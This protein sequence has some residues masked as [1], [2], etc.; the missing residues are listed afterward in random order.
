VSD[1]VTKVNLYYDQVSSGVKLL[2]FEGK[3]EIRKILFNQ[4]AFNEINNK[5]DNIKNTFAELDSLKNTFGGFSKLYDNFY[6]FLNST[7]GSIKK[8]ESI[9]VTLNEIVRLSKLLEKTVNELYRVRGQMTIAYDYIDIPV[10]GLNTIYGNSGPLTA[11]LTNFKT[12]YDVY[13]SLKKEKIKDTNS[14]GVTVPKKNARNDK[15][16]HNPVQ[17]TGLVPR[18]NG[19]SEPQTSVSVFPVKKHEN[20]R[21][22][23]RAQD[24]VQ[25]NSQS[26]EEDIE[27][28][29]E[30]GDSPA[31]NE[32]GVV[33][34]D[35]GN[36]ER[37]RQTVTEGHVSLDSI[38][39]K[40]PVG[41]RIRRSDNK[42]DSSRGV[43]IPNKNAK[44]DKPSHRPVK[45]TGLAPRNNGNSEPHPSVSIVGVREHKR[46]SDQGE[47]DEENTEDEEE[48]EEDSSTM[49]DLTKVYRAVQP[50]MNN[51][52]SEPQ[53]VTN[54]SV[55][56]IS[57]S[58]AE[59]SQEHDNNSVTEG[60]DSSESKETAADNN[61]EMK[62]ANSART[63]SDKVTL[64][65]W[66][67]FINENKRLISGV[68]LSGILLVS[69]LLGLYKYRDTILNKVKGIKKD[70]ILNKIKETERRMSKTKERVK[71]VSKNRERVKA[72]S[73]NRKRVKA[74]SKNRE[75]VKAV[76]KN[77][78]KN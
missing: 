12:E 36:S 78:N 21:G 54:G 25:M 62:S 31:I 67:Q 30:E 71:A 3:E 28:E 22:V 13:L 64:D 15:T 20:S 23:V 8:Y 19:N 1:I 5:I 43:V 47:E 76:S 56:S 11:Y 60:S 35:N 18:N 70:T 77:K 52:N 37:S 6:Y 68:S 46:Q 39:G 16:R 40:P 4:N 53:S 32:Y 2:Q 57:T 27:D 44:N 69:S 74:V 50:T 7:G 66:M 29:E 59:E 65:T 24:L 26:D 49:A 33:S 48:E 73:K 75:R 45:N 61:N 17:N 34:M 55:S 14:K 10:E 58:T 38:T 42:E 63:Q 9:A 72:V 41:E 51:G